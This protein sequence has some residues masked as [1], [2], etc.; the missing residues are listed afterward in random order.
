[1]DLRTASERDD[2]DN[3]Y[4]PRGWL[5]AYAPGMIQTPGLI[6][7]LCG[8]SLVGWVIPHRTIRWGDNPDGLCLCGECGNVAAV[9]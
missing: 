3:P 1:M 6:Q 7:T 9:L 8:F 4:Q 2:G 5:P